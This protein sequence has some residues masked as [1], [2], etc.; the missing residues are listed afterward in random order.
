MPIRTPRLLIRPKEVGDGAVA[1]V[2]V[3]ETWEDLH[4]WMRWAEHPAA[5]TA[6]LLEVRNRQSMASFILR[7]SIELIGVEKGTNTAVVWCGLHDIDWQGRQCDTGFWVRKSAQGRG[8]ATE[9]ANAMVRYA[10]G[11]LGMRRV[12]LTHS[13]G[14]EISRRIAEKLGF[15]FEGIQREANI[16]PGGKRADRYCYALLDAGS[17]PDLHVQW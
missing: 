15:K 5:L 14:N 2:A 6:E 17:L 11:C 12:G 4:K 7:E 10:F 13:D 9:A 8:I 3:S 1:S 16:L